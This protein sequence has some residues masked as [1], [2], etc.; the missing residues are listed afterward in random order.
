MHLLAVPLHLTLKFHAVLLCVS[1]A[2][3]KSEVETWSNCCCCLLWTADCSAWCW[4]NKEASRLESLP[5][6][7]Q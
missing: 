1:E 5:E 4:D 6:G 3:Q 7:C 2:V